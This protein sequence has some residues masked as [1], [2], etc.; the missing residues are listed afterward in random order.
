MDASAQALDYARRNAASVGCDAETLQGDALTLLADLRRE[1][2]QFD[3][4]CVDPP[5]FIKRKKDAKQGLEAYTRVNE[6]GLDLVKPGGMFMT[7]S[8]SHHLEAEA[9]RTMV[10]RAAGKRRRF[11]RLLFQGF[12][13]PDHPI[14]PA[15]PE[16]AYLKTFLFHL[17]E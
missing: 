3:I 11:A 17:P 8:C 16:T 13:G 12:Q 10:T 5:A 15:M 4:V 14:H 2:R 6:L 7:C 9:L 1:G